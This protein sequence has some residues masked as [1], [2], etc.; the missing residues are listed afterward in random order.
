[1]EYWQPGTRSQN[2]AEILLRDLVLRKLPN[3]ISCAYLLE[4]SS[5]KYQLVVLCLGNFA[6]LALEFLSVY[7]NLL[8]STPFAVFR[9]LRF[10][11]GRIG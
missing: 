7:G 1:M 10:C 4:D 9:L 11:I 6:L 2:Q 5:R 3:L 8:L